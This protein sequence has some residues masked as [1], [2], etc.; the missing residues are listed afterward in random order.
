MKSS[1]I[2]I[3]EEQ[4]RK[5]QQQRVEAARTF[6]WREILPPS[7][8]SCITLGSWNGEKQQKEQQEEEQEQQKQD[9]SKW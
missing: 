2:I 7:L 8:T 6:E 3:P 9:C 5:E 1:R 4:Q